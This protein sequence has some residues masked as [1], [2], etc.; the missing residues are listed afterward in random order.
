M[1]ND[2]QG[3]QQQQRNGGK[4]QLKN[5]QPFI[6]SGDVFSYSDGELMPVNGKTTSP[7]QYR[8]ISLTGKPA[9]SLA[10]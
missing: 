1:L 5:V 7:E 4:I 8:L 10:R 6:Y 2:Q 3:K 9:F